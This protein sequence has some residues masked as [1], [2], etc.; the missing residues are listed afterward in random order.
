MKIKMQS[1]LLN[2]KILNTIGNNQKINK[3]NVDKLFDNNELLSL[4]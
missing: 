4:L 1:K 3:I 2:A